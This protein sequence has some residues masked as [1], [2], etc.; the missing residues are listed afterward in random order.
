MDKRL[1]FALVIAVAF[2]VIGAALILRGD[3]NLTGTNAT[4]TYQSSPNGPGPFP[5]PEP[6]AMSQQETYLNF[7]NGTPSKIYLVE[8]RATFGTFTADHFDQWPPGMNYL[9]ASKGDRFVSITGTVRNDE[10]GLLYIALD[11]NLSDKKGDQIGTLLRSSGRPEFKAA[12][13]GLEHNESG[14]FG[15]LLKCDPRY[16]I[17]DIGRY[18]VVLAWEPNPTPPP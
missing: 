9:E 4:E 11:A 16:T 18:E 12:W 6:F 5:L 2:V 7:R 1:A 17:D 14:Q 3:Q 10:V 15:L 8:S 13:M